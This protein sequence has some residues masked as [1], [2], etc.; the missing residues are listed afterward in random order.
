[1]S[2]LYDPE[3]HEPLAELPWSES[4]AREGIVSIRQ[5]VEAAFNRDRLWPMHPDDYEPGTPVDGMLRGLDV[6]AAGEARLSSPDEPEAGSSLLVGSGGILLVAD[7]FAPCATTRE[8]LA[9]AIGPTCSIRRTSSCSARRG[10]CSLHA[11]CTTARPRSALRICGVTVLARCSPARSPTGCGPRTS[12]SSA[13][14]TSG[15]PM[16][17]PARARGCSARRNGSTPRSTSQ[18][19]RCALLERSR[20]STVSSRTGQLSTLNPGP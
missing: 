15:Q 9:D 19:R 14:D 18:S 3:R 1:M 7:Q 4:R 17:S 16:A 11:R 8:L 5:D 2:V 12:T 13:C 10:R 6:G 20:F